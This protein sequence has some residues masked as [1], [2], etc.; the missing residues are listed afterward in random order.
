LK[1][2]IQSVGTYVPQRRMHNDEIASIVET[3]DEW[4]YSHTG[5]R[6]RHIAAEDEAASDLAL[7][8]GRQALEIAGMEPTDVDLI[9]VATSTPDFPGLPST[10]SIVQHGLGAKRAGAMDLV[11]A[12]TGFVYAIDTARAYVQSGIYRHV[13][14]IGSEVY[15]KILNWR[16]RNTCVLF[17]DGAGAVVVS[18]ASVGAPS[19]IIDG[20]LRSEGE[21]ARSLERTAGGSRFPIDLATT[22]ESDLYLRMDGRRVY[23]FAVRVLGQAIT[24]LLD[25]NGIS[26]DELAFI[27][28]HQANVRIL[29][30]AARRIG[31]EKEKFYTNIEEYANTSAASIPLAFAEMQRKGLLHRGDL[32]LTVGFGAGLAYGG[33]LLRW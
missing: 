26:A 7:A 28:P 30:A 10:A 33:N 6:W 13:L 2:Y 18:R 11:A 21:G 29:H 12:C 20:F 9:I 17:G 25:R 27:V 3:S 5:I 31:I 4:I 22:P 24:V 14:V 8:A 19:S 32:I 15:S 1:A 23:N 16:D